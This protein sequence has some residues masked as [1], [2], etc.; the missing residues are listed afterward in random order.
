MIAILQ[1]IFLVLKLLGAL[2]WILIS[3]PFRRAFAR[4]TFWRT[5]RRY[6]LSYAE[7]EELTDAFRPGLRIGDFVRAARVRI[8]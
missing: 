7:A 8:G 6:G 5:L 1:V 4:W 2:L 3:S